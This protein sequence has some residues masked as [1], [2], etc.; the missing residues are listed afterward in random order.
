MY[1]HLHIH[2]YV[3]IGVYIKYVH[4]IMLYIVLLCCMYMFVCELYDKHIFIVFL[5]ST[6][7]NLRTLG[8]II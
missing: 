7:A 4:Y 3:C 2:I 1:V 6:K 5:P 8:T